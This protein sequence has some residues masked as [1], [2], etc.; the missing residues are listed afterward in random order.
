MDRTHALSITR[1]AQL[2]G[3]SRANVYYKPV[4]SSA[5]DLRR[6]RRID[7]LHP[8]LPFAG[9]RMLRDLLVLEGWRIG[10]K[11]VSTLMRIMRI[12]AIFRWKNTSKPHP[13]H[14]ILVAIID[15]FSRQV[16]SWRLSNSMAAEFCME[17]LEESL[18]QFGTPRFSIRIRGR[19]SQAA[20]SSALC[21]LRRSASAWMAR[22]VGATTSS[23]SACGCLAT[24]KTFGVV[25][26]GNCR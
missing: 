12:E 23:L 26:V 1:Q 5:E 8:E 19:N 15:W 14:Q 2:L 17:A 11:A 24:I 3:I 7:E 22:G 13:D 25:V 16:L 9:A 18:A 4:G 21:V 20:T 6:M 10:R